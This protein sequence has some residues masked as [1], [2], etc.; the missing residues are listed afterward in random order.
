MGLIVGVTF[1][2]I[3]AVGTLI[4]QHQKRDLQ[5]TLGTLSLN[6]ARTGAL[7][8]D[9]ALHAEVQRT[10]SQDSDADVHVR[11]AEWFA[12]ATWAWGWKLAAFL[13]TWTVLGLIVSWAMR[14]SGSSGGPNR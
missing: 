10:L 7:L 4:Y 13:V 11:T 5:P 1:L 12:I 8:V 9:P 2:A 3:G 14:K 6:I